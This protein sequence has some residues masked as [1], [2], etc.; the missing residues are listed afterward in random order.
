MKESKIYGLVLA[1]GLSKRMG[2][3]KSEMVYRQLPQYEH[4]AVMLQKFCDE[5][6]ISVRNPAG[7]HTAFP[8]LPDQ[9]ASEGPIAGILT[10]LAAHPDGTWVTAPVDMPAL[11]EP[12]VEFLLANR[13]SRHKVTCF[14]NSEGQHP[15]PL[16]GVWE[17][18]V[19]SLLLEYYH[20]GGRSVRTF[21]EGCGVNLLNAPYPQAIVNI[22]TPEERDEYL[23][24]VQQKV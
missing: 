11:N 12:T 3:D 22:N 6:F 7:K 2:E 21:M 4:V 15:E 9:F 20:R 14:R 18:G 17:P 16:L 13:S 19:F 10:A 24:K 1:G 5:V 8:I 23:K